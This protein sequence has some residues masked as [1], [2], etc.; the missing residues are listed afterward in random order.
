MLQLSHINLHFDFKNSLQCIYLIINV[1]FTLLENIFMNF[2]V[3]LLIFDISIFIK[4]YPP[5]YIRYIH[6]MQV[7]IYPSKPIFSTLD[8]M[9]KKDH[10][11]QKLHIAVFPWLAFGHFL[12]FLHLSNHLAQLGH[13]ISFIST[14][15]NLRRLTE[16]SPN[17]SASVTMVPLPLPSVHGLPDSAES[18]SEVPFHLVP[19]LKQAYD[20]LQFPLTDFLQNSDV[21]WVIL[22]IIPHWLP[23]I[24]TRLAINS[25]FFS[26][27]SA[28][29]FAFLGSPEDLLR[30]C[31][32]P[33][34]D[35]TVV[36]K[37]IPFPSN[38]AFR[39]FEVMRRQEQMDPNASDFFRFAKVI[40]GCRFV[41]TR[42]CAE[43]E[44]DSLSLLQKLYQKPVIPV[45]LLPADANDSERDDS[46]DS[47]RLWLDGKTQ[48]S[49][50]YIALGT[51]LTLSQDQMN[52]LASGI[53]KSG[54]PFV[55][56]V[57]T[58]DHPI[59][60][61]F[62]ERV[63]GRGL[64]W[65]NWAP[66]KRILAHP[67]VGGFLTHCGWSSVV[68][69]LGLG[70]VLIL[71]PGASADLGLVARLL[72]D[73]RVGL[74]VPRDARDGSFTANSV[75]ESIRR[76]MVEEEGEEIRKNAWA[77]KEIFGNV[78]LQIKYLDG[79]ASVLQ[80]DSGCLNLLDLN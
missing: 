49:V 42:S 10:D 63:S 80:N 59:I 46:W 67:S 2:K 35:L 13:R 19:Y 30:R 69:A 28:S 52:E 77:M 24:A 31:Q 18:T 54:L 8:E 50:L 41:A 61:G 75:S 4:K 12:P 53:E 74:E 71:F 5:I 47:L 62:E 25:V 64:V 21:N 26:I 9:K 16:I 66:Q 14:P 37:W 7:P 3:F 48:N 22:D 73:K 40:E 65:T 43:L 72:T 20:K 34:E 58:R 39:L 56:V 36:P 60:T 44:A 11:D 27:F 55:W 6:K 76:V 51:E 29:S 23:P 15:K 70:R 38:V 32:Q 45:G 68:E 1:I 33:V 57:K 78:K 79:F 17:Q